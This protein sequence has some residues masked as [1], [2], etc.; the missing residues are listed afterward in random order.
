MLRDSKTGRRINGQGTKAEEE[1]EEEGATGKSSPPDEDEDADWLLGTG[2]YSFFD[3]S[4]VALLAGGRKRRK[5]EWANVGT[6]EF[7]SMFYLH[8]THRWVC[9]LGKVLQLSEY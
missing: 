6:W 5:N 9:R 7:A 8:R 4:D 3:S 2:Y 1:E